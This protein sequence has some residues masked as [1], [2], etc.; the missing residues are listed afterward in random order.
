MKIASRRETSIAA[1]LVTDLVR[2]LERNGVTDACD[3][4]LVDPAILDTPNARI[5]GS[6]ME[7]VWERSSELLN[8]PDLGLHCAENF[9]PGALN[10][11]GY[12]LLSCRTSL[13][14]LGRLAQYA[15]LLNE[16]MRVRVIT[17]DG[18]TR[19]CYDVVPHFN[20]YLDRSPRHAM[21]TMACGT[22]V[23]M[24]RLTAADVRAL[25]VSFQH[26]APADTSEHR[27]IFGDVVRFSQAEN[28]I[29]FRSADLE[30]NLLSSNPALLEIFDAQARQ[31]LAQLDHRGPLS[32]RI[33]ELLAK[34]IAV[35]APSL[36]EVAAE[37][38]MSERSIQR[39]LRN[40]NTSYRQ[41]V[42]DV[43]KEMA[44]QHLARPGASA[45]EAAFLLGFS[46]PSAF[47][48]AF[49]RWTGAAPTQYQSA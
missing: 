2:Y 24:R 9:H 46:E 37:L 28:S 17:S 41:L 19:V 49:R 10:I 42:E 33:L 7:R 30:L 48:R 4:L 16:G 39:A 15:A 13:E 34:R 40:E 18:R 44:V 38:A 21:E 20:N 5:P 32:R 27:R 45:T 36:E 35:A 8:D 3:A 11:L 23:T 26:P 43:R 47:T 22:L 12:V 14:A 29:E 25:A 1:A 31:L 6:I